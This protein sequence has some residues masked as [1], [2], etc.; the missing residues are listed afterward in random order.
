MSAL[1]SRKPLPQ[2]QLKVEDIAFWFWFCISVEAC[3]TF[4]FFRSNPVLG[5]LFGY[6]P[7]LGFVSLLSLSLLAGKRLKRHQVLRSTTAKLQI[8]LLLW[9]GTTLLWTYAR[10]FYSAFGYW[11][12]IALK[13]I[14][15]LLLMWFGDGNKIALKSLQ[16]SV[17]GGFAFAL[18]A[19]ITNPVTA[20]G[21]LG[22]EEF[23]HP[24]TIGNNMA[25]CS[26]FAIY[27]AFQT[28]LNAKERRN[29]IFMLLVLLFTLLRSLSKTS[30]ACFFLALLVYSLT[31][32]MSA[33][34]K[35]ILLYTTGGVLAVSAIPLF[36][37]LNTYINEQQG[38]EA[39]T[40]ATGRTEIWQLTWEMIQE[41]PLIGYGFQSFRDAIDQ[42]IALRLVHAH[43]EFSNIW[44]NLG[45]IGLVLSIMVY[46]S[47]Y[48]LVRQAMRLQLPQAGLGMALLIRPLAKITK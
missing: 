48:F 39:L 11:A 38:G 33:R 26:L 6:L 17:W 45:L 8:M 24:N 44:F 30:I 19:L 47:Y 29:L 4:L 31:T 32:K 13:V 25:I 42:I 46:I 28:Q 15:T 40:T 12:A 37:Y 5:T 3:H 7:N 2:F 35:R 43:N 22:N 21:R 27:L 1:S 18:V 20:D 23:F 10:P 14:G 36:S 9:M 16:G 41:N 34:K